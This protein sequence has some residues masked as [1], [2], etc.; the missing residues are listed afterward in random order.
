MIRIH[1]LDGKFHRT[2]DMDYDTAIRLLTE[3]DGVFN[4][5][6]TTVTD[7]KMGRTGRMAIPVRNIVNV[8]NGR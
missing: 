7:G 8:D 2:E 1:T 3:P 5:H 6:A 4:V